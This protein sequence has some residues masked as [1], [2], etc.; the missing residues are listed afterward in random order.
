MVKYKTEQ[1]KFWAGEF[2]NGYA[3]RNRGEKFIASQVHYFSKI[4][5]HTSGI[6]S[7]LEFGANIGENLKA[8]KQLLPGVA[9]S[10]IEINKSAAGEIR[11]WKEGKVRVYTQSIIDFKV[12][13]KRDFVFVKGVLIHINPE[14]LPDVYARLYQS[15][16]KYIC[17][18]EYY[19][20]TP[21]MIDCR[22]NKDRLFKRDFC[23][24]MMKK[25]PSLKLLEYGFA[26]N[27]DNN[28]PQDD[29]TWFLLEKK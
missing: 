28:F 18:G 16:S 9:L 6:K 5:S 17:I 11:K 23:G 4:L 26:Y 1:E 21:T 10:A 14:K 20:P 19:N 15:S 3:A 2:G 22:G 27:G 29:I 8:I 7:V 25:Y 13:K 12:D 24:E